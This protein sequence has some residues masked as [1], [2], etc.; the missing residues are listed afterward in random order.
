MDVVPFNQALSAVMSI[1]E[2]LGVE[3]VCIG[4]AAG[5]IL[6]TDLLA[7]SNSPA[8][9]VSS[10]DGYGVRDA[11][12]GN[13]DLG[14]A[15]AELE[16]VAECFAGSSPMTTFEQSGCVRIFTGAPIPI[17]IDRV[18]IQENVNRHGAVAYFNNIPTG[19]RNIRRAGS[20]FKSGDCLL[21]KG[22]KLHWRAMTTAAAADWAELEVYRKPKLI[23]LTTGDE[24]ASPGTAHENLGHIPETVSH[25][26]AAYAADL[27][28]HILRS[29]RLV[30][31]LDTL[32][33]SAG[34]ALKEADVIIVTGGA[35]VGE[36]DY[37][38]SMFGIKESDYIFPKVSI[39]P[40]KPAWMAK[41]N[42]K[43]IFG[44]PG[45]PSSA[46]VTARLFLAPLLS[47]LTGQKPEAACQFREVKCRDDLPA[48]GG[49]ETFS[50]AYL[51]NG[52]AVLFTNQESNVQSSLANADIL[53]R[54]PAY[55]PVQLAGTNVS[56]LDF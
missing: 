1:A 48:I 25:S 38:R 46:L 45:N 15:P 10:M 9:D 32:A 49:R 43:I 19:G 13:A 40:G 47:G 28:G 54:R 36:K 20:D 34:R 29:E 16:V 39:K 11:D 21:A 51:E 24:L 53:I 30:D 55:S 4:Q 35:S 26:I 7:R 5:R 50:R 3:T 33:K 37:A 23:I 41:R 6:A 8:F 2:P 44:L 17:G 18:I 52:Q 27:G 22:T 42:D 12:L 14:N 31:D 56:I